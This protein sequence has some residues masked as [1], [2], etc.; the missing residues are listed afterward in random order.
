MGYKGEQVSCCAAMLD[1]VAHRSGCFAEIIPKDKKR[2]ALKQH[3]DA[4]GSSRTIAF[5]VVR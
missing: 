1:E 2:D 5:L 4:K 3:G